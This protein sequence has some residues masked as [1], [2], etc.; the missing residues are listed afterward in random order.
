MSKKAI[1]FDLDATLLPMDQDLFIKAYF[2]SLAEKLAHYGYEPKQLMN[3]LF[4]GID[5]M[6][7]NDGTQTNENAFWGKFKTV[8]GD[9]A[10]DDITLHEEYYKN[11][12]DALKAVCGYNAKANE[13]VKHLKSKG[14]RVILATNPV[15]PTIATHKRIAWAGL[16]KEDFELITTFENSSYCK[17]NSKYYLEILDKVGLS[18]CD[19]IMIGNDTRDDMSAKETGMDVFL[20]TDCLIN[21]ENLDVSTFPNGSFD[22]LLRYLDEKI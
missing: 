7:N 1:L 12:F 16:D 4:L 6:I 21:T 18:P 9:K 3:A 2:K 19:C 8:F 11:D 14:V 20:L 22:E 15:F 13:V 10:L 17:P 5:A